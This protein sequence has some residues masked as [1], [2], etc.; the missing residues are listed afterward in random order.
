L[1]YLDYITAQT[2]TVDAFQAIYVLAAGI[3]ANTLT[4]ELRVQ[5]AAVA[6]P[7]MAGSSWWANPAFW[8]AAWEVASRAANFLLSVVPNFVLL[9]NRHKLARDGR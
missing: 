7:G 8:L 4:D 6:A 9:L 5:F 1:A 2:F 3:S